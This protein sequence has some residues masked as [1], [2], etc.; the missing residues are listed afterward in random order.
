MEAGR[1]FKPN[2]FFTFP[3]DLVRV[4]AES[5]QQPRH[6]LQSRSPE[7][8]PRCESQRYKAVEETATRFLDSVSNAC[9]APPISFSS[10]RTIACDVPYIGPKLFLPIILWILST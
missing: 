6:D 2:S 3:H 9:A 8:N 7:G 4:P 5:F 10:A 1:A